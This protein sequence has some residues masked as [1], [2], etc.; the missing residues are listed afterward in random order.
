MS[1]S[2]SPHIGIFGR[3]NTG[4]SSLINLLTGQ[5]IAIVSDIPGTT[6]DPVS[7]S[8]EIFGVGPAVLID[9]GGIDDVGELGE[10]RISKSKETIKKVDCAILLIT[11]NLFDNFEI[12]LIKLF[13]NFGTPYLI[14]HNKNDISALKS[15]TIQ[16]I[17]EQIS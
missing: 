10:K 3:R 14:V 12:E 2:I 8:V 6:T 16:K 1:K 9:T 7:K 11:D 13:N 4:K 5:E 15:N 17:K